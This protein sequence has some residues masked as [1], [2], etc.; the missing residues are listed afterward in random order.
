VLRF[1]SI[2]LSLLLA[3]AAPARSSEIPVTPRAELPA[4]LKALWGTLP[5]DALPTAE[6]VI[7]NRKLPP[8]YITKSQAAKLGWTP[9]SDLS[10]VAAG[11]MIGGDVFGNREGALPRGK[12]Y[13]EADIGYRSGRRNGLRMVFSSDGLL[14]FTD[15]YSRWVRVK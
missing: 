8:H 15:H 5:S 13:F 3:L 1:S 14:F 9:G 12:K 6:Y 4:R 2:L 7:G 11:K 10:K